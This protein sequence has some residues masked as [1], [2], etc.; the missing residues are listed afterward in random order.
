MDDAKLWADL[1]AASQANMHN[2]SCQVCEALLSMSDTARVSVEV[3]L[4][5]TMI[6]GRKLAEILTANGYPAGRRAVD[7]HRLEGHT[8]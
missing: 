3:H 1:K 2:G 8:P 4:R 6:G 5:G 7:R